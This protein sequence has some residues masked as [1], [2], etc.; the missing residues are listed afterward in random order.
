MELHVAIR[1]L[2]GAFA[3]GPHLLRCDDGGIV[4]R[5]VDDVR[6]AIRRE[7]RGVFHAYG[8]HA[9]RELLR[10][11]DEG[12]GVRSAEDLGTDVSDGSSVRRDDGDDRAGGKALDANGFQRVG[13][14][15]DGPVVLVDSDGLCLGSADCVGEKAH[16]T[17]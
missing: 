1:Q 2:L 4:D 16:G 7:Q 8:H 6:L 5:G 3:H 17:G 11:L 14:G 10:E 15:E 12:A 9:C 13:G